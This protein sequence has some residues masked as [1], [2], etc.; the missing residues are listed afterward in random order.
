MPFA[1]K[2]ATKRPQPRRAFQ[3]KERS[4][5]DFKKQKEKGSGD[6]DALFKDG[7][8]MFTAPE[9]SHH[10]RFLPP[11]DEGEDHYALE[12]YI[13]YGIG[14]D[15]K[16]YWCPEKMGLGP[17]P[18]CEERRALAEA[19]EES[20][21]KSLRPAKRLIAYVIDRKDEAS[22]PKI[23]NMPFSVDKE[24]LELCFDEETNEVVF[25]DHP[26]EGHDVRFKRVGKGMQDTKYIAFKIDQ[27]GTPIH[28]LPKRMDD[29]L[30][31]IMDNPLSS[32]LKMYS[33][34]YLA[35]VIGTGAAPAEHVEEE[36]QYGET[37]TYYEGEETYGAETETYESEQGTPEEGYD[38]NYGGEYG[39]EPG[40]E[41]EPEPEP[42]RRPTAKVVRK[43]APAKRAATAK[44]FAARA[45]G[46]R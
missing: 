3:Y 38:E 17:C 19:G 32:T 46:R 27:E 40:P 8:S 28:A 25:I 41:V 24:L 36:E 26:D 14:P 12:V 45:T 9:G 20:A 7:V 4:A 10:V 16:R 2:V 42:A 37:E 31:F 18:I 23:W 29:W 15:N 30:G 6:F 43:K 39:E 35:G 21:A 22:G 44:Q 33:Y 13:H 5:D 11:A 34:D 1:K